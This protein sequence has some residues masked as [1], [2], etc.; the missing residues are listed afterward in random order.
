[1]LH[2]DFDS[3]FCFVSRVSSRVKKAVRPHLSANACEIWRAMFC[4]CDM[5]RLTGVSLSLT[6][7]LLRQEPGVKV[8][9][10]ND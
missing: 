10:T 2:F 7:N 9:T 8:S 4:Q 1:M 5:L 3:G 6:V